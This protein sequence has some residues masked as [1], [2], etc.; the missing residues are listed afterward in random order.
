MTLDSHHAHSAN[1]PIMLTKWVFLVS[2][3]EYIFAVQILSVWTREIKWESIY[4]A[5]ILKDEIKKDKNSPPVYTRVGFMCLRDH[6]SIYQ[7]TRRLYRYQPEVYVRKYIRCV[8]QNHG[9]QRRQRKTE[10]E[11]IF[12]RNRN[13]QTRP[14]CVHRFS[15]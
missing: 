3:A 5:F 6:Q 2:M 12:A 10:Q 14:A 8:S 7:H 11:N 1:F 15:R 4:E 13:C 9:A